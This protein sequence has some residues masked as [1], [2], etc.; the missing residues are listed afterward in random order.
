[1]VVK[2][3]AQLCHYHDRTLIIHYKDLYHNLPLEMLSSTVLFKSSSQQSTIR[4][5][6]NIEVRGAMFLDNYCCCPGCILPHHLFRMEAVT[7]HSYTVWWSLFLQLLLYG[8]A[9]C[10][11]IIGRLECKCHP[12]R[13]C[14]GW[15]CSVIPIL[16]GSHHCHYLW[17]FL[18]IPLIVW[19]LHSANPFDW[20]NCG[21]KVIIFKFHYLE[22]YLNLLL[23]NGIMSAISVLGMQCCAKIVFITFMVS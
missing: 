9:N 15:V 8:L 3:L 18:K 19:T 1:M 14:A 11:G 13:S 5:L 12:I 23:P 21:L 10:D 7:W 20:A 17:A 22:N 2:L 4:Y 16:L 6:Y